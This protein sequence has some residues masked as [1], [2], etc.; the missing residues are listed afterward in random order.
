VL[1]GV[2]TGAGVY[3]SQDDGE[4]EHDHHGE[5]RDRDTP[6]RRLSATTTGNV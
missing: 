5:Q 2:R 6:G 4:D 3:H 1:T